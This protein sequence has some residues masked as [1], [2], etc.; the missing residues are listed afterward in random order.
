[1]EE[2]AL[3]TQLREVKFLLL[4]LVTLLAVDVFGPLVGFGVLVFVV[5]LLGTDSALVPK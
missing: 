5:F 3:L 1:M 2:K 4:V